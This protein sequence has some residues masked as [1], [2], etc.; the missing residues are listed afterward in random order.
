[1]SIWDLPQ[2]T[3]SRNNC[4][5][6]VS[7]FICN[8]FVCVYLSILNVSVSF[9]C[10]ESICQYIM[11]LCLFIYNVFVSIC[12]YWMYLCPSVSIKF[13]G[14]FLAVLN[15]S[16]SICLYWVYMCLSVC[17]EWVH[18]CLSTLNVSGSIL[19]LCLGTNWWS[20]YWRIR[21]YQLWRIYNN[22]VQGIL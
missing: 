8:A 20:G 17:T 21:E 18:V 16:V 11:Y 13:I 10:N 15:V 6:F 9:V 22:T 1:M 4:W 5:Y 19:S 2:R 7:E 12:L 3:W 14:V